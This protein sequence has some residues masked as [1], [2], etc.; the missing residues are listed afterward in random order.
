VADESELIRRMLALERRFLRPD[1]IAL[2]VSIL[3]AR[4]GPEVWRRAIAAGCLPSS[5]ADDPLRRFR[6]TEAQVRR[7]PEPAAE[8]GGAGRARWLSAVPIDRQAARL[9]ASDPQGMIEA[10][11]HARELITT[12]LPFTDTA[13]PSEVG[14]RRI[15]WWIAGCSV[16]RPE[17]GG[18][19][20]A[21]LRAPI[22]RIRELMERLTGKWLEPP[23]PHVRFRLTHELLTWSHRWARALDLRIPDEFGLLAGRRLGEL[24]NPFEPWLKVIATGY[25]PWLLTSSTIELAAGFPPPGGPR[26]DKR[27]RPGIARVSSPSTLWAERLSALRLDC[28]RGDPAWVD[29]RRRQVVE[30]RDPGSAPLIHFGVYGGPAV[31]DVL[32]AHGPALDVDAVDDE[33]GTALML[34]AGLPRRG[35]LGADPREL[36]VPSAASLGPASIAWLLARGARLEVRDLRGWTALHWAAFECR[37]ANIEVL[38]QRDAALEARDAFGR[39]PLLVALSDD[40]KARTFS[41]L[42]E[43]IEALLT[44]GADADARDDQGWTALHYLAARETAGRGLASSL[45]RAG[46]QPSRDRLGRTPGDLDMSATSNRDPAFDPRTP[47]AAGPGPWPPRARA[48]E[49]ERALTEDPDTAGRAPVD[50]LAVWADWLQNHGDARGELLAA[51]LGTHALGRKRRHV[52]LR[53]LEQVWLRLQAIGDRG[54][55]LADHRRMLGDPR[56]EVRRVHGL[57]VRARVDPFRLAGSQA[58]S[59]GLACQAVA[60]LVE[61]EPLLVDLRLACPEI[62]RWPTLLASLR[63][64]GPAPQV[65]RLVLG[66]LPSEVP[67]VDVLAPV[68]PRARELRLI[69][70]GK[71]DTLTLDWPGLEILRVRHGDTSEWGRGVSGFAITIDTLHTLDLGLPIGGRARDEEVAGF[72]SLIE[73]AGP[74]LRVLRLSP[75]AAEFLAVLIAAPMPAGLTSLVLERV[76]GRAIEQLVDHLARGAATHFDRLERFELSVTAAVFQQHRVELTMLRERLPTLTI[77]VA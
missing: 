60:A 45:R 9:L 1:R 27:G 71:L 7:T 49:L 18:P 30:T 28:M 46:T 36:E 31:L 68:F 6:A 12:L 76:R 69:G 11:Q 65:R 72:R 23:H 34:A 40:T 63:E 33:G 15:V 26:P 48:T 55:R 5:W 57:V 67:R 56:I 24:D 37:R 25:S 51:E 64:L 74:A 44:A 10:E 47:V 17:A 2:D 54:L 8:A 59:I 43:T 21:H 62:D 53:E 16:E 41:A 3:A 70:R 29:R 39:T 73:R 32:A 58:G 61:H 22:Q 20:L 19:P 50:T 75:V 52:R 77:T 13:R 66:D 35:P 14:A 4:S 42:R 38:V